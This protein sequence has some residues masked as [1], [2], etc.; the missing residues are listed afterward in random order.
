VLKYLA[1]YTHRVAISNQ[2]LLESQPN[3]VSFRWKDYRHQHRQRI[4]TLE[5]TEFI[6]RF[7]LHVLPKGFMRIRHYGFL[8][9]RCRQQKLA[10]CHQLLGQATSPES[11]LGQLEVVATEDP[12]ALCPVCHRGQ[13]LLVETFQTL[14]D[15]VKLQNGV[16]SY[17]TS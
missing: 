16:P 6:R 13:L 4:M 17:D 12:G 14:P 1:R 2:R 9:N 15:W 5:T 3:Q 7:L 11:S 10:C 8:A